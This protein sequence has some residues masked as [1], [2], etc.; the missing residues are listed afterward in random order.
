MEKSSL[1]I[2][3]NH[4]DYDKDTVLSHCTDTR[5]YI[6]LSENRHMGCVYP[7]I[8]RTL[9]RMHR[10]IHHL[11]PEYEVLNYSCGTIPLLAA[12]IY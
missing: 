7:L 4:A 8:Y 10:D 5:R 12:V 9:G 3:L 2:Y 11:A 6:H 1:G